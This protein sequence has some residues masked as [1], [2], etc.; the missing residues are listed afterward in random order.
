IRDTDKPAILGGKPVRTENLGVSWP[1]YD[2]SDEKM[3]IDALHTNRWSEY[4]DREDEL[5]TK[6][7][8]KYAELM[9][10][11]YCAA[12][13]A[14]TTA[15]SSALRAIDISPGDEVILPTNTFIATA[16]VV[17][18]IFALPVFVDSDP[19]TF[20]IDADKIEERINE[21]TKAILPVHI[22][23][24]AADMDKIMA[25]SKKY[26]IPVVEDACQAH[27]GEWRGR[28]LGT[29]GDLG[30]FSF[31][32]GKSLACGEGGAVLGNNEP[33]MAR[34]GAYRN[35]GRDPMRRVRKQGRVFPGSNYRM[36]PFQASLVTAQMRRL[37]RQSSLRDENAAHLEKLLT[38]VQGVRPSAK[39]PG[40]TRRAYF[41]YQ[42]IYDKKYFNGLSRDRFREAMRAEGISLSR[43]IDSTLNRG[44][45]VEKYLSL[46]GFQNAFS[47]KRLDKYRKEINCPVNDYIGAE[48]GISLGHRSFLGPKKDME[49]IVAAILKVQK[50]SANLL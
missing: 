49:D 3:L 26:N 18:N 29:I 4:S 50:Y 11:K 2:R 6:F 9:G 43:G 7:E 31:Q 24:G 22:G 44:P 34:A 36:T 12:T 16:Q 14:G 33:L 47:K 15:L 23:G 42:M 1:I 13:N 45:F 27:M 20:M 17:F 21:S 5:V 8:K 38:E 30:C 25:I 40:Q 32:A 41:K 35:N 37:E 10:A 19:E 28:K 48:T 39:Y 46:R